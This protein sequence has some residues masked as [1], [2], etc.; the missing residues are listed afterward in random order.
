MDLHRTLMEWKTDKMLPYAACTASKC[1]QWHFLLQFEASK[2]CDPG[3][4]KTWIHDPTVPT[5]W[6]K[7]AVLL[8]TS[9][10]QPGVFFEWTNPPFQSWDDEELTY[11]HPSLVTGRIQKAIESDGIRAKVTRS[12]A[13]GFFFLRVKLEKAKLDGFG[14]YPTWFFHA[15]T[16]FFWKGLLHHVFPQT[17]PKWMGNGVIFPSKDFTKKQKS[18]PKRKVKSLLNTLRLCCHSALAPFN[19]AFIAGR[20]G[21]PTSCKSCSCR[22]HS[23][24]RARAPMLEL[25]YWAWNAEDMAISWEFLRQRW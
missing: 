13:P 10:H 9:S 21:P 4:E 17:L 25:R 3:Y 16:K 8:E 11:Q 24:W 2:K 5:I 18:L 22:R 12:K 19:K 15:Q 1:I 20:V 23:Q 7:L 6:K 14:F